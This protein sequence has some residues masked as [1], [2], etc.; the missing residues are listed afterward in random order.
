M[1]KLETVVII[2]KVYIV[3]YYCR[4]TARW[5]SLCIK[6]KKKK[7]K[8]KKKVWF[9]G[10]DLLKNPSNPGKKKM[11]VFS[12]KTKGGH[13]SLVKPCSSMAFSKV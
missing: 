8:K 11:S 2:L 4:E 9:S 10:F 1:A 7:R 12:L 3:L 5:V 13:W 6:T